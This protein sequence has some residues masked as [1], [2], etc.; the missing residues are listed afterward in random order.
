MV[1]SIDLEKT[2]DLK[3]HFDLQANSLNKNKSYL[4]NI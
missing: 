3:I 1:L 2:S 4:L